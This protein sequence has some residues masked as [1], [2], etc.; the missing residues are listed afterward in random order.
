MIIMNIMKNKFILVLLALVFHVSTFAQMIADPTTWSY[1]VKKKSETKYDLIFNLKL[2]EHWHIWSFN[3]GGDGLQIPPEFTF[4]NNPAIKKLGSVKE[5]GSLV[6]EE[7]D[8]VDGKVNYFL[9]KVTYT[10]SVEVSKN[11]SIKGK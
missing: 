5:A 3:P 2:K 11:T 9:N 1:E 8:G 10:Q 4:D 7:I 6:S